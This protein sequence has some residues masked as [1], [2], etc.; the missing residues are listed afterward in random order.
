[1]N[2]DDDSGE[3]ITP[4]FKA[5]LQQL[6]PGAAVFLLYE[7]SSDSSKTDSASEA[8][9]DYDIALPESLTS[10]LDIQNQDLDRQQL[11]AKVDEVVYKMYPV[12]SIAALEAA[13]VGQA[14]NPLWYEHRFGR[15][16]ASKAK[17][18]FALRDS[19]DPER[20]ASQI[21]GYTP[22]PP[23]DLPALKWGRD[24]ESVVAK[25]LKKGMEVNHSDVEIKVVGM[26]VY[27]GT[28]INAR[29]SI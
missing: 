26:L 24:N 10:L 15:V 8:E 12:R 23:P 22:E 28:T 9:D 18:L 6:A 4:A 29:Y 11:L 13:T 19:T 27:R 1:M 7:E 17:E 25:E 20:L 21:M 5:E 3:C 14:A 16:T 2:D